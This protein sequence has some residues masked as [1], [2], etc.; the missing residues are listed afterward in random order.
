VVIFHSEPSVSYLGEEDVQG[1]LFYLK[2][3]TVEAGASSIFKNV[4]VLPRPNIISGVSA[5]GK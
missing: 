3:S 1:L 2:S 4:K 5:A